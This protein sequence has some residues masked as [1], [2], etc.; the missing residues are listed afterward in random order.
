[1]ATVAL[2]ARYGVPTVESSVRA[3]WEIA[4]TPAVAAYPNGRG[5]CNGDPDG[6]QA[7]VM[8]DHSVP[9]TMEAVSEILPNVVIVH[10]EDADTAFCAGNPPSI[11]TTQQLRVSK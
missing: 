6:A 5:V 3:V 11:Y 10:A 4:A 7:S 1:M 2:L 9:L 8:V